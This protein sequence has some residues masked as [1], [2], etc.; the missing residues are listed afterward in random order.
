MAVR[1]KTFCPVTL[2]RTGKRTS[3]PVLALGA[4]RLGKRSTRH[5]ALPKAAKKG[6]GPVAAPA[7]LSARQAKAAGLLTSGT[8]GP[9]GS[10]LSSSADLSFCLAS[11]LH[12]VAQRHGS[13]LYNLTWKQ[14]TTPLGRQY[15]QLVASGRRTDDNVRTGWPTPLASV[16]RSV[17]IEKMDASGYTWDGKKHTASL[18]HAVKFA[19]WATPRRTDFMGGNN[20]TGRRTEAVRRK[21]GWNNLE[22]ARTMKTAVPVRLTAFGKRLTGSDAKMNGTGQLNP[23]HS[24]WLMGLPRVW[25]RCAD[26]VTL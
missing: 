17:A 4:T 8:Y 2:S 19:S 1:S 26:M 12:K 18:E 13:T 5:G 15:F 9:L 3:S 25:G 23:E 6:S 10:T 11:R 21:T 20:R 22:L 16:R 14:A 7:N 24:R